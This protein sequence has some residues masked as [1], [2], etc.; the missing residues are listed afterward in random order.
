MYYLFRLL[1][2][3]DDIRMDKNDRL[4]TQKHIFGGLFHISNKL[5]AILDKDLSKHGFTA[6][7]WFLNAVIE[8]FFS[9][10]PSL[11]EVAEIMGSSRQNVKQ[12]ALKLEEKGFLCL[13]KDEQDKRAIRLRLTDKSYEFWE[14]LQEESV[15]FLNEIFRDLNDDELRVMLTG[16]MKLSEKIKMIEK[17]EGEMK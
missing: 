12:I 14:G 2:I 5:Q 8:E 10:P 3:G 16:I 17:I 15:K 13:D 6:K 1:L 7:Q 11:S 4:Y 9:S